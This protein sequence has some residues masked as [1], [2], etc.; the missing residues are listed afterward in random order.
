MA[1]V[2]FYSANY[3][4]TP[5]PDA[6]NDVLGHDLAEWLR[7]ELHERGYDVSEVIGEDYGY[8][9]HLMLNRSHYWITTGQY[10]PPGFEGHA[11]SRWLVGV[12]FDPGCLWMWRLF[13][14]PSPSDK[15]EI[16]Q[17]IH[18][19]LSTVPSITTIEWWERDVRH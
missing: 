10:E 12:D 1:I 18:L 19:L 17:A 15:R 8:G 5:R 3:S 9:F 6:I 14:R 11:E 2:T 7:T 13:A 4:L 16:T